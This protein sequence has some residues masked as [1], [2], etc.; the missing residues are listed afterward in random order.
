[1]WAMHAT[2]SD[3]VGKTS[4]L[5][6]DPLLLEDKRVAPPLRAGHA[7]AGTYVDNFAVVGLCRADASSR[8]QRI[9]SGFKQMGL[10]LHE[11]VECSP[12]E[13][14]VQL[15]LQFLGNLRCLRAKPERAWR[16]ALGLRGF[17][18]CRWFTGG[19]SECSLGMSSIFA[20][21]PLGPVSARLRV[22]VCPGSSWRQSC[23]L[24]LHQARALAP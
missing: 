9:L 17:G 24:A 4:S 21:M 16:L 6:P 18:P 7:M 3:T 20:A 22:P 1:M 10:A 8:Y 2:V 5:A 15:G 11:L 12:D 14:L 23:S 19:S 13:P